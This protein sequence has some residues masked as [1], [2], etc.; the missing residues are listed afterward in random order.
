[1]S[2]YSQTLFQILSCCYLI[3]LSHYQVLSDW[4]THDL[5]VISFTEESSGW[6]IVQTFFINLPRE[7]NRWENHV[8]SPYMDNLYYIAQSADDLR[9]KRRL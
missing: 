4:W 2:E 3:G 9:V 5:A 8:I 1:M 6:E 7:F